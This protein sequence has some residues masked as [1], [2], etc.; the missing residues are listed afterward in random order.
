MRKWTGFIWLIFVFSCNPKVV[1]YLNERSSF[2]TF[3]TYRIVSAKLESKNVTPDN[4]LIFDLIKDN[5]Q[6][7]MSLRGYK[8]SNITPDLTL[9]YEVTSNTRVE[10]T[11]NQVSPFFPVFNVN[12]RTIYESVLLLEL[13]NKN[14]K[15]VWQGSYDLAQERKEKKVAKVIE[16]AVGYIFTTYP[17]RALTKGPDEFLKTYKPDKKK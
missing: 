7:Q 13:F 10:T 16:K 3:E 15:L 12:T 1:S 14:K 9:R 8:K 2:R 6:E 5:I 4:T 11:T 17:Y